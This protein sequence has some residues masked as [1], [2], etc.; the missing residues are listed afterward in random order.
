MVEA[1]YGFLEMNEELFLP[2]SATF[3]HAK[4]RK[5]PEGLDA[6][7]LIFSTGEFIGVVV[8][9]V[10][11]KAVCDTPVVS[12]PTVG[13]NIAAFDETPLENRHQ[14]CLGA[15]STTLKNTLPWRS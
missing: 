12:L 3:R 9:S 7:D 13:V 14:L 11:P 1:P 10:V 4:H 6:V 5:T 8:D 2:D 15:V